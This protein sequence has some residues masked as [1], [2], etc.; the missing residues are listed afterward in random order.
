MAQKQTPDSN[1]FSLVPGF[2]GP[3]AL[4]GW[5]LVVASVA[6]TWVFKPRSRFRLSGDFIAAALYP[7]ISIGFLLVR[8][9]RFPADKREYLAPN[10]LDMICCGTCD[11]RARSPILVSSMVTGST[12]VLDEEDLIGRQHVYPMIVALNP[13]LRVLEVAHLMWFVCLVCEKFTRTLAASRKTRA[14][15]LVS[16]AGLLWGAFGEIV[17]WIKMGTVSYQV[18]ALITW[19]ITVSSAVIAVLTIIQ[20][21]RVVTWLRRG[22]LFWLGD[23]LRPFWE[24]GLL[25]LGLFCSGIV[26]LAFPTCQF[27]PE[28]GVSIAELD[29]AATLAGVSMTLCFSIYQIWRDGRFEARVHSLAIS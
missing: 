20:V 23:A 13:A 11:H 6:V 9:V 25:I 21:H 24:L 12:P 29:Q 1:D 3:G 8:I 16:W 19:W 15:R 5:Y 4:A 10:L 22:Q 26:Y 18:L 14:V 27:L 7:F 28:S 17:L 2:F